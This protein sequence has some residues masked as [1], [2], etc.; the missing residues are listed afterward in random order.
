[1]TIANNIQIFDA[2][3]RLITTTTLMGN[4]G[5]DISHLTKGIYFVLVIGENRGD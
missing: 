5:V 4:E 1:L 3:G 2:T